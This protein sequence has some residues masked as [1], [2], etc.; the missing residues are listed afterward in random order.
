LQEEYSLSQIRQELMGH[1]HFRN[2][3]NNRIRMRLPLHLVPVSAVGNNFAEYDPKTRT[4]RKKRGGKID[5]FNVDLSI[6]YTITDQLRLRSSHQVSRFDRIKAPI[7]RILGHV[8]DWIEIA[9]EISPWLVAVPRWVPLDNV[10]TLIRQADAWF[11]R[12]EQELREAIAQEMGKV[13]DRKSAIESIMKVQ[14]LRRIMFE[15]Q[16]PD[17]DL[18]RDP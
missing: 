4:M 1:P 7:F 14:E 13:T 5:P 12:S 2:L 11:A 17:S 18:T 9:L 10:V 3:V 15:K 16:F 8:M 6:G